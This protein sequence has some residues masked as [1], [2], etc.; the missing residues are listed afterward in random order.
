MK[1]ATV[2]SETQKHKVDETV[3]KELWEKVY[4]IMYTHT[5]FL[6]NNYS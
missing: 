3:H 4:T 6:I 1:Y 5:C 2:N